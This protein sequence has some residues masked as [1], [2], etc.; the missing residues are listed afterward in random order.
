MHVSRLQEETSTIN[1][2]PCHKE[3]CVI[4]RICCVYIALNANNQEPLIFLFFF[5]A[6]SDVTQSSYFTSQVVMKGV[7]G[8]DNPSYETSNRNIVRVNEEK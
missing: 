4:L 5:A 1:R 3:D 2:T 6:S 7:F 8:R